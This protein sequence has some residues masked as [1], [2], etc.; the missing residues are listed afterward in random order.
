MFLETTFGSTVKYSCNKGFSLGGS[1]VKI[2]DH[3]GTWVN[4]IQSAAFKN[5]Y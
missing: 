5:G 3:K 4:V 2:C 1:K